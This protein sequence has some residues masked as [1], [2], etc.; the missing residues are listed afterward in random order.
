MVLFIEY[1]NGDGA[2]FSLWLDPWHSLGSLLANFPLG[3][4]LSNTSP[5]D[6]LSVVIVDGQWRWPLITDID[7]LEITQNLPIIQ[8][9]SDRVTWRSSSG[10]FHSRDAYTLF[11]SAGPKDSLE[12]FHSLVGYFKEIVQF[13]Y[14]QR[15]L[16]AIRQQV[17]FDWPNRD[18]MVDTA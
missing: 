18:L 11:A 2:D 6:R 8:C 12:Q 16:M 10:G 13:S 1:P 7:C 15:C 4:R 9:G 5:S 17:R 14:S 3:P